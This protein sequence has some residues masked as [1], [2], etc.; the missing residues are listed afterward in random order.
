MVTR[1]QIEQL[2]IARKAET[3][4]DSIS[5]S[6]LGDLLLNMLNAI[7]DVTQQELDSLDLV[8]ARAPE[9]QGV[10]IPLANARLITQGDYD[11]LPVK[12]ENIIY[13]IIEED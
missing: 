7:D 1:E 5:P 8:Q 2:I 10:R 4:T 11:A 3:A 9:S 12:D 6:R 13:F